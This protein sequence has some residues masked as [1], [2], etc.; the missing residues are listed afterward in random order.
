[1]RQCIECQ[2]FKIAESRRCRKREWVRVNVNPDSEIGSVIRMNEV[3][4]RE[5]LDEVRALRKEVGALQR[6]LEHAASVN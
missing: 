2:K 6:Q 1:M 5:T 3:M 4:I